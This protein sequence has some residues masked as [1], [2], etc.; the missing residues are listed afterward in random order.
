LQFSD[1]IVKNNADMTMKTKYPKRFASHLSPLTLLQKIKSKKAK[2]GV[3]GLG[4]VGLPLVIEFCKKGF[5]VAGFDIDPKKVEML[6]RGRSYIRHIK[7]SDLPSRAARFRPTADFRLLSDMDCIII[8]VPTPLNKNREPDMTYVFNTAGTIARYLKKGQ[9][10]VLESTTYPGTTDEDMRAILEETGLKAGKD[11]YLAFSPEREDPNNKQY[12]T[13]TIPKVVGGYTRRCLSAAKALYDEIVDETVPVS[14]TKTAEAVKLLE[15]IYRSVNIAMVNELKM[16][17]DRMGIDI[18]EVIAAAKTKPFGFQ[19][20]YPGPGLG[21]HCIPIDPF[22]LTWKAREYEFATRFIELAG[23]INTQMPYYVVQRTIGALNDRGRS[24]RNAKILVLGVA[25]KKDVS[26]MRESPALKLIEILRSKGARV[27]YHDPYVKKL[28]KLRHYD[29]Q[30][31]SVSLTEK[32]VATYDAL[33]I[34]TDHSASDYK[35]LYRHAKL[36]IDTRNAV[37]ATMSDKK[38]VKA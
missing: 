19:A 16:L 7:S 24:V 22:Y 12:S 15:N 35:W 21:G 6:K 29:L 11:Y 28:P 18:W 2:I 27:D 26:D 34:A 32:K 25:Y 30:M 9:L 23:E 13:S 8:C 38:V 10:V 3:I 20:F 14:S 5:S 33:I 36:I 17:F 31:R 37:C 1:G 4:Y